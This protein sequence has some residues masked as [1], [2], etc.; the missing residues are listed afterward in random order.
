MNSFSRIL[1]LIGKEFIQML[2]D[3]LT[4]GMMVGIPVMQ[5]LLFGYASTP[6]RATCPRSSRWAITV[7]PAVPSCRR[8]KHRT[9]ST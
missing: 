7:R 2:R 3:R 9:I 8:W 6:I 5:L 1:A 4:F